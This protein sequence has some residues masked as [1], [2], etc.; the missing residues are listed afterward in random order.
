MHMHSSFVMMRCVVVPV[1]DDRPQRG[2]DV[3]W[4]TDIGTG[5]LLGQHTP[6]TD[7]F[8]YWSTGNLSP[9]NEE[10][11]FNLR[12]PMNLYNIA[13]YQPDGSGATWTRRSSWNAGQTPNN[14]VFMNNLGGTGSGEWS[15][16][17]C[18]SPSGFSRLDAWS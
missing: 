12:G 11:T 16:T 10:I 3:I 18:F 8:G 7:E 1:P 6:S 9:F 4:S 2:I 13:V 5:T 15:S 14:L 17:I